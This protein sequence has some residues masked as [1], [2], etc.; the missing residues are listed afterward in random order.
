[1]QESCDFTRFYRRRTLARFKVAV[2]VLNCED[3]Y[4]TECFIFRGDI[5]NR[6]R[7]AAIE[8]VRMPLKVHARFLSRESGK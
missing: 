7:S 5:K 1:M 6:S 3:D 8:Q 4:L 2:V